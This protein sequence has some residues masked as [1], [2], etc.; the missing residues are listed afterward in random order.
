MTITSLCSLVLPP[1]TL[2]A[3]QVEAT[4]GTAVS[5][6]VSWMAPSREVS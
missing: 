1:P 5:T 3:F 6:V 4:E 2:N